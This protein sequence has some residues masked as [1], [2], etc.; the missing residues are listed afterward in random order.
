MGGER[1][2]GGGERVGGGWGGERRLKALY[3][4]AGTGIGDCNLKFAQGSRVPDDP[5]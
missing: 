1:V 5:P 2:G 3:R 4:S